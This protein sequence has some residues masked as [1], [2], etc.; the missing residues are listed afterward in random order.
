ML[1]RDRKL[2]TEQIFEVV[3]R[4]ESFCTTYGITAAQVARESGYS[5]SVL[6]QWA[7]NTYKG[8]VD[9]V[10]HA[11][12]DWMERESRRQ[13][14]RRPKDYIKTWVAEDVRTVVYQADK[15]CMMAAIVCPAGSGKT[16]VLK[17]L[18]EEM[19]GLYVYC[20]P[21]MRV[22]DLYRAIAMS[23]GWRLYNATKGELRRYIIEK[24]TGTNRILFLDEAHQL[25]NQIGSLRGIHD[26]ARVPIIMAGTDEI[27]RFVDDRAHGR[28]QFSSRCIRYNALDYVYNAERP[29][30][31]PEGRDLFTV[32]EI[33]AF[34]AL[35]KIRISRD[36]LQMLWALA[37]LPNYGTLR[38]VENTV[39]LVLDA[40]P[41]LTTV[42]RDDVLSALQSLVG[43][44]S[45]YLQKLARRHVEDSGGCTPPAAIARAG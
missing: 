37:C 27:L 15:R 13:Q 24:L 45:I 29:D 1:P 5:A 44:D 41:E 20:E 17:A 32:E 6:S 2:S 39:D 43:S 12:N 30:G 16:K 40:D 25:K 38:L 11:L 21:E 23:L 42:S 34:F 35:K 18:T 26:E 33:Q 14:A 28:G 9:A 31:V 22:R 3:A 10:T 36:A 7:G 19:R 4:F 8:N